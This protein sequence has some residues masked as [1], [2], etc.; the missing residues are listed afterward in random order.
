ML[1]LKCQ[2]NGGGGDQ[3]R[4]EARQTNANAIIM[5]LY[6]IPIRYILFYIFELYI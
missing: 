1:I 5:I 6:L 2:M 3:T 4:G